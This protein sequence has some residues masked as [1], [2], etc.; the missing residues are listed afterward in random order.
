MVVSKKQLHCYWYKNKRKC[1]KSNSIY[2]RQNVI[3]FLNVTWTYN[4]KTQLRVNWKTLTYRKFNEILKPCTSLWAC[5]S[6]AATSTHHNTFNS[7]KV[8]AALSV[9]FQGRS[10]IL[11]SLQHAVAIAMYYNQLQKDGF[12]VLSNLGFSVSHTTVN[13]KLNVAKHRMRNLW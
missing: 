2:K 11:N 10:R 6:Q 1:H 12:S 9:L 8:C 7:V 4:F 5:A 3:V 13:A